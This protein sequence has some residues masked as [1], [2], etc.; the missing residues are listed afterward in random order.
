MTSR[1]RRIRGLKKNLPSADAQA[2]T[3]TANAKE[4]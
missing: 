2:A 3:A 4:A 1:A